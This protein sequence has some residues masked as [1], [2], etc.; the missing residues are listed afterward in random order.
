MQHYTPC[1]CFRWC[2]TTLAR[3]L[4]SVGHRVQV[5]VQYSSVLWAHVSEQWTVKGLRRSHMLI[6]Q[7]HMLQHINVNLN[8]QL[9]ITVIWAGVYIADSSFH[10]ALSFRSYSR[11]FSIHE[12]WSFYIQ[13]WLGRCTIWS[14]CLRQPLG[15]GQLLM[16]GNKQ[17]LQTY[18]HT[19]Q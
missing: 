4:V 12:N 1:K 13:Q 17:M 9:S 11:C 18:T 7:F 14:R 5:C 8:I 15:T 3:I 6:G 16:V 10:S 19:N 2:T